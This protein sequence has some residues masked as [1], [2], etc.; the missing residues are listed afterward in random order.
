MT[1]META[2]LCRLVETLA[3]SVDELTRQQ[4]A[5]LS[6]LQWLTTLAPDYEAR[7]PPGVAR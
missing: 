1:P 2:K 4:A 7:L 3:Q 6:G 5:T